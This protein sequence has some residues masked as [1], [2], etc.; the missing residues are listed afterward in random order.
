MDELCDDREVAKKKL[1]NLD[2]NMCDELYDG[3]KASNDQILY[4][5]TQDTCHEGI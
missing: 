4:H 3:D 1:V 2:P 5:Y